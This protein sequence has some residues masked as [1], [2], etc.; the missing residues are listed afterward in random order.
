M[1][2]GHRLIGTKFFSHLVQKCVTLNLCWFH[3]QVELDDEDE[4]TDDEEL[5]APNAG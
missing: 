2:L 5:E 1:P 3:V 4:V